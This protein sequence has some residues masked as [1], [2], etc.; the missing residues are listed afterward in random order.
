[1][2]DT[3]VNVIVAELEDLLEPI[4]LAVEDSWWLDRLLLALGVNTSDAAAEPLLNV[5]RSVIEFKRALTEL[6]AN[7]SPSFDGIA[8]VLHSANSMFTVIR[9][10]G[11]AADSVKALQ[12]IGEDLVQLLVTRHVADAHPLLFRIG[13]LLTVVEPAGEAA[14]T[15]PV[16]VGDE[17]LRLPMGIARIHPSRLVALLRDPVALLKA[18]YVNSLATVA[19]ADAMADK[20]FPRVAALLTQLGVPWMY[21]LNDRERPLLGNAAPLVDHALTIY[22]EEKAAGAAADIGFMLMFSSAD[23]GDL[24]LVS[25]PFGALALSKVIGKWTIELDFTAEVEAVAYGRHGVTLVASPSTAEVKGSISATLAAPEEGPAFVFGAPNGSRIEVGGAQLKLETSLSEAQQSLAMSADVSS[26]AIVI[27]PSDGDGFLSSILPAEGLQAKFDL[28]LAWSNERGLTFRG[29]SGLDATLPVGLSIRDVLT[30]PTIHLSLHAGETGLAAEVSAS[31]GAQI[32]PVHTLVDRVGIATALSFP[33]AGG[34]LGVADLDLG[35]KP[36]SGIGLSIDATGVLTGGGFLFHDPAQQLYAGAMQL[37]LHEQITL[38]AFGL[39][40]TQ[41]PDGSRGYSLLIFIT[42]DGFKPIPLGFGFVLQSIGGMVGVNRTFDQEVLKAGLKTDTLSTLLFP[43]DPVGNATALIQALASAFPAKPGSY[44]L[45]L[46]ARITWFTPTLVQLDLALILELV[47]ARR[48]LL[49]LGRVSALLPSRDNDLI[50]L[51]LD[52]LGVL[53]FDAGT[54][55]IDAVLVDSRLAH[56]FPITGSAALRARWSGG[57]GANFVLAAGGLNPRFAPPTGFP[58][59]ERVAIALCSGKNPRLICD[60]YLAIT[61]NTVQFG[62]RA[63]LYAEAIGFSVTGNLGF[64]A[65]VTLLPPHFIVDFH[66]AVQLKRGSH[67][68][69]KV[70][71]DGTLEG[72]LPLRIAARAKFELLWF[73]FSVHFDF[74]LVAGDVAQA[75]LAAVALA[76]ELAKA[77]ADPASWSTRRAP[78]LAHGVALRSLPPGAAPVLDPLG[79]LVVQQQVVPLNTGR[80]VDTYGGAPVAGPRRFRVGATLNGRA[81]TAVSGAFAPARYFV[82]SDDDKLVAPSFEMM[83]AGL[84]LGDGAMTFDAATIVPA[85]LEYRAIVLNAP[86]AP[87]PA[88]S[89]VPTASAAASPAPRRYTLPVAALKVQ[90]PS[91]A[92]ARVPVR[93]VGRA[94]FRNAAVTPAATLA[95]PRWRIV[96]VSDDAIASV[97][98]SVTTWSDYR[99]ALATLNRGGARW[100]MVPAHE[101]EA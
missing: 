94:R 71:L 76:T 95:A 98:P 3:L 58:S 83:D 56:Q 34:N 53:D 23:R 86:A 97:D 100:L 46:V 2:S 6:A 84:V 63:S 9:S 19:D 78:G 87:G 55:A 91:G 33:Q 38:K 13:A 5:L 77:L 40:A 16:V 61:A 45:G 62:A 36:P 60:A 28:G 44:L 35:F 90:R 10:V 93:H 15:A 4:T 68:L 30:V 99:A 26:S 66:A 27:A 21:G 7:P 59:L 65:L 39:I 69:F 92:A 49:A 88:A 57:A 80:D 85:R 67:N 101:L 81:G 18:E 48:R 29:A 22:I 64:D 52:A 82:M 75:A 1:M 20:L 37:S 43:R 25:C 54:L 32:G 42:A 12:G 51:N 41:M 74:T 50:R 89:S 79:Q 17:V 70:T 8:D 47:G 14:P 72:P 73:S 24:G 96:H 11:T 31:V